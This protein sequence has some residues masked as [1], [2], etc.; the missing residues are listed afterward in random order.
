MT[1]K[2]EVAATN[3]YSTQEGPETRNQTINHLAVRRLQSFATLDNL[4]SS[5]YDLKKRP[6]W[7]KK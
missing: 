7:P 4:L 6:D 2:Q 5:F 3:Y 1:N